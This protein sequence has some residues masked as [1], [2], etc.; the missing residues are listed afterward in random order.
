[1]AIKIKGIFKGLKIISQIFAFH[2]QREMEIGYPTDVKHVSHIDVGTSDARPSWMSAFRGLEELP[3]GSMRSVVQSRQTSWASLDFEQP[4]RCMMPMEL[5]QDKSGQ[6]A[7][8][9][10]P[11][12]PRGSKKTRRKKTARAASPSS[13]ASSSLSRSRAAS[14][15]TACGDFS[16]LHA[17]AGLRVA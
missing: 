3:A 13:S 1:M 7:A 14:F 17:G 4:L 12:T 15:A 16:E 8:A 5:Y 10:S 2:K 11:D 6:E 9:S